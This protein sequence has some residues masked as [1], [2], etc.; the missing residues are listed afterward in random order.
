LLQLNLVV[1]ANSAYPLLPSFTDGPPRRMKLVSHGPAAYYVLD[2]SGCGPS[3]DGGSPQR[4][5]GVA[6]DLGSPQGDGGVD[7]GSGGGNADF[8]EP[9]QP[10]VVTAD[11]CPPVDGV[12]CS[13]CQYASMVW[14]CVRP[15]H[16]GSSE[17]PSPQTCTK[18]SDYTL[19][20]QCVGYDGYC[21]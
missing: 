20:G 4:D 2:D 1:S 12:A 6:T 16:L 5:G 15:C 18:L 11:S 19:A 3:P 8:G 13:I 21:M 9:C 14:Q 10:N 17:C 7:L